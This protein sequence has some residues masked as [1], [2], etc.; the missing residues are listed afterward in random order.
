MDRRQEARG[1]RGDK[2]KGSKR[3]ED[4]SKED[5][6]RGAR[7]EESRNCMSCQKQHRFQRSRIEI[8]GDRGREGV[9]RG[10]GVGLGG[11]A[12]TH[13]SLRQGECQVLQVVLMA[14]G[15][16]RER[17]ELWRSHRSHTLEEVVLESWGSQYG[18]QLRKSKLVQI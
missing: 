15:P 13:H 8:M 7:L 3:D 9:N 17:C 12:D 6:C 10:M 14:Q 5:I 4:I 18:S 16:C 1:L 2:E 11:L